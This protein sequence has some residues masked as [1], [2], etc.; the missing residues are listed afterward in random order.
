MTLPSG[1]AT[2]RDVVSFAL[3]SGLLFYVVVVRDPPADPVGV[4]VGVALAGLPMVT[5]GARR[6]PPAPPER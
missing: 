1:F 4:A 3:G 5:L 6:D 2:L